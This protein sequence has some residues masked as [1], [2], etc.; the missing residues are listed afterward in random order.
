M[1]DNPPFLFYGYGIIEETQFFL[2]YPSG[3]KYRCQ[4]LNLLFPINKVRKLVITV[5]TVFGYYT[6]DY[7][8]HD[9]K[10][11]YTSE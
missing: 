4:R 2:M 6:I 7:S 3:L 1:A 8:V 10:N 5:V 11:L 9:K